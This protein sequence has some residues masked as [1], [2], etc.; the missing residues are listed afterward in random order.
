MVEKKKGEKWQR[1]SLT[2]L[3]H[4]MH[5]CAH[6]HTHTHTHTHITSP[7]NTPLFRVNII[8]RVCFQPVAHKSRNTWNGGI[9]GGG[10][11]GGR[12]VAIHL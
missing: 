10:V 11:G 8:N 6:T 1:R 5:A 3:E 9:G 4:R 2:K 7:T 12:V